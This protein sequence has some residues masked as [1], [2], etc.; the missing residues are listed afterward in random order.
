MH[1]LTVPLLA[2]T[3]LVSPAVA[4]TE[5]GVTKQVA[6][7]AYGTV[8]GQETAPLFTRDPLFVDERIE[9]SRK[10]GARL[11]FDDQTELWIGE[12]SEVVLDEYIYDPDTGAGEFVAALGTG[13]FRFVT[14]EMQSEG[15]TVVTPVATIGVRGTDFSVLVEQSGATTASC[16]VGAI[17]IK[18]IQ[19]SEVCIEAGQT[20]VV[21]TGG[22]GVSVSESPFATPPQGV[23]DIDPRSTGAGAGGSAGGGG[24]GGG[25]AGR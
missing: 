9:T 18:P 10:G 23:A 14:G 1:V 8:P 17:C 3:A 25:G 20:A 15:F 5:I 12:K 22:A 16:Y 19:G 24:E 6:V 7:R 4:A 11:E 21:A 13:L 2:T